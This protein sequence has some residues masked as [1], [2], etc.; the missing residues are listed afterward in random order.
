MNVSYDTKVLLRLEQIR[1]R[2]TKNTKY[3]NK[4]LYRLLYKKEIYIVAY[5]KLKDNQGAMTPAVDT[6]TLDGFSLKRIENIIKSLKNESFQPKLCRLKQLKK[7][8]GKIR[9]LGIQ[10]PEEKVVQEIIRMILEAIF[11]GSFSNNSHGFRVNRGCH[12]ALNQVRQNFDGVSYIIEGDIKDCFNSIDHNRLIQIL[13]ERISDERFIRLIYKFLKAGYL[14]E[15]SN[16]LHFP[17]VGTPQGSIVSPILCNIF[18]DKLDYYVESLIRKHSVTKA[19]TTNNPKASPLNTKKKKLTKLLNK[20]EESEEK[21]KLIKE[22]RALNLKA[23]KVPKRFKKT[24]HL[25]YVRYADDWILGINGPKTLAKQLKLE[26]SE[27]LSKNLKLTLSEEKTKITEIRKETVLFLG[28]DIKLQRRNKVKKIMHPKSKKHFLK[29]TTGHQIKLL[30]PKERIIYRLAEKGFCTPEGFPL[31][32]KK[33]TSYDDYTI[34]LRFNTVRSGIINYYCLC[35]N[36]SYLYRVDYILRYSL[37]KTLAHKHKTS[38]HAIFCKH[39]RRLTVKKVNLNGKEL[40]TQMPLFKTFKPQI[41]EI[42]PKDLFTVYNKKLTNVMLL[43]RY[44]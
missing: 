27:F 35:D 1:D 33:L 44:L 28:Y 3:V 38:C 22:L 10:G 41:K 43:E 5:N 30:V 11:E 19:G 20:V 18:L 15:L 14:C 7:P 12:T 4:D 32:Y 42:K 36:S 9:P 17:K 37:A 21:R 40:K 13:R 34:V 2:N 31:S 23:L 16:E 25:Y 24:V 8:N 29:G 26:I 39:G 6:E